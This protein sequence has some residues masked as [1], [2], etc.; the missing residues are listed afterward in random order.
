M[1]RK[2]GIVKKK[3]K[4]LTLH[5][6][7]IHI[8]I[9]RNRYKLQNIQPI[10]GELRDSSVSSFAL[11]PFSIHTQNFPRFS[12]SVFYLLYHEHPLVIF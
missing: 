12:A 1:K 2:Y 9:E 7:C 11:R 6:I 8:D 4:N 3:K 5:Y 10:E